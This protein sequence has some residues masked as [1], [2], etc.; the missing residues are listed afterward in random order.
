MGSAF[1]KSRDR[2]L[3]SLGD[4]GRDTGAPGKPMKQ[5]KFR[6]SCPGESPAWRL[7]EQF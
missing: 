6:P 5:Q 2:S 7:G 3:V 1:A 4:G